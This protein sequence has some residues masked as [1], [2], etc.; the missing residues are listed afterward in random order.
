ME[1]IKSGVPGIDILLNGGIPKGRTLLVS[2]NCGTGKTIF[3]AQFIKQGHKEN[4][5][6][7]YVTLEQS[8]KKLIQDSKELGIDLDAMRADNRLRIIGGPVGDVRFFKDKTKASVDDLLNEIKEVIN[9]IA[10]KR[11]VIDS[12]NLFTMLFENDSEKR[13][14]MTAL[15]AML[16]NL[17]CTTILTCEVPEHT[18]QLS[19][20]GFE[21]FVVDGVILLNRKM[22]NNHFERSISVVKMRGVSHS[23]FRRAMTIND[24]GI[25]VYP[26]QE[27]N[28]PTEQN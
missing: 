11:V 25:M 13:H 16:E 27:P 17:D 20:H 21:D 2:G 8:K 23:Q 4:D 3:A 22:Y 19:W 26:D 28:D 5:P 24:K 15:V 1:R 9:E 14:A 7:V 10:A 18:N 6:C 12:V